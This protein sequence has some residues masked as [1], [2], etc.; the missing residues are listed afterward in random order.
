MSEM[1]LDPRLTRAYT[2]PR[3]PSVRIQHAWMSAVP[4]LTRLLGA[5]APGY[6]VP[7]DR[8]NHPFDAHAYC[9]P[10]TSLYTCLALAY[11]AL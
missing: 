4:G 5:S 2:C 6:T 9:M 7:A 11:Q 3:T 10:S 8:F 1:F